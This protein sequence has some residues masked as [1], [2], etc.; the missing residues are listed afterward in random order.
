MGALEV[1]L[2]AEKDQHIRHAMEHIG[3]AKVCGTR[4][5]DTSM[6]SLVMDTPSLRI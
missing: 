2:T 4:V 5:S 3:H 6:R 1:E